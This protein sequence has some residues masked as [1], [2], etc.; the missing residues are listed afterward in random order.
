[1]T[2]YLTGDLHFGHKKM[3]ES[4][5]RPFGSVEEMNRT[6]ISNFNRQVHDRDVVYVLGDFALNLTEAEV[7][8]IFSQ[9]K[10]R[11]RLVL[12][13][14]DY[15]NRGGIKSSL[16]KLPWEKVYTRTEIKHAGQR[17]ILDHYAGMVW[18]AD[19]HG[20]YLAYGHSHGRLQA[21]PGAIDVGVDAQGFRPITVE[22]FVRQADESIRNHRQVI[23]AVVRNLQG[24]EEFYAARAAAIDE[25]RPQRKKV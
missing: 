4:G 5:L 20:T 22:E 17:I 3:I 2:T 9:L 10:G 24:R 7:A 16:V 23:D 19:R 14:H 15:D 11:L 12:G 21:L 8:D 18:N 13:N 1:M 25:M 6:L